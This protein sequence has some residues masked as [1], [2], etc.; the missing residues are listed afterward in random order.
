MFYYC[1]SGLVWLVFKNSFLC[2]NI[3]QGN[4]LGDVDKILKTKVPWTIF[5]MLFLRNT[6]FISAC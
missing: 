2:K 6:S 3:F 4:I 5:E 1:C